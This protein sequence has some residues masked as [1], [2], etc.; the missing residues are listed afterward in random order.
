MNYTADFGLEGLFDQHKKRMVNNFLF[1][2]SLVFIGLIGMYFLG[3]EVITFTNLLCIFIFLGTMGYMQYSQIVPN[4]LIVNNTVTEVTIE[5]DRLVAKT[6]PFKVLFW[7]NKPSREVVFN[8]NELKV[9]Q[10][11]YPVKAIFDLGDRVIKLTDKEKEVYIIVDY[12][13]KELNDKLLALNEYNNTK[14]PTGPGF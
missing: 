14:R 12:F 5:E 6:S 1:V 3:G 8:I 13:D 2:I 7:I 11:S 4:G 10:V 9:R